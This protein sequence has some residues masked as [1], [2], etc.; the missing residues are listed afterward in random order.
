MKVDRTISSIPFNVEGKGYWIVRDMEKGRCGLSCPKCAFEGV[1]VGCP[2][3]Y[4]E[5]G[6]DEESL[7]M[8]G[9][10]EEM[11][12]FESNK[13]FPL[14]MMFGDTLPV[15]FVKTLPGELTD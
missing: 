8:D 5:K 2:T 3:V 12:A 4:M 1:D 7:E 15:Y 10:I 9:L 6:Q 13:E 14:C 11:P